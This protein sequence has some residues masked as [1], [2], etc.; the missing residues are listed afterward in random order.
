VVA[1]KDVPEVSIMTRTKALTYPLVLLSLASG[2]CRAQV[3]VPTPS[4]TISATNV[5]MSSSG[6]SLPFTLASIH[7]FPGTVGI[8]VTQPNPPAGTKLPYLEL[9]G[10]AGPTYVLTAI[11]TATGSIGLSAI[12]E[13]SPLPVKLNLPNR[14]GHGEGVR[15]KLAGVLM[16]GLGS[17]RK[18]S[19]R[20]E[21]R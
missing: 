5:T 1:A 15:W 21:N 2:L 12:P 14:P 3:P 7:G 18:R 19:P 13:P 6:T 9:G 4:F 20:E 11:P 17:L 10:P 8:A 16:L